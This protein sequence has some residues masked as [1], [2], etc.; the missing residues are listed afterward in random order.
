MPYFSLLYKEDSSAWYI[1][2]AEHVLPHI[3]SQGSHPSNSRDAD[4]IIAI[5]GM[6]KWQLGDV[7]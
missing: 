2:S 4:I 7:G 5:V 1:V 3:I 6:R